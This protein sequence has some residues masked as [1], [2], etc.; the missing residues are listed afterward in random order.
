[1]GFPNTTPYFK[2]SIFSKEETNYI[3][4]QSWQHS[5]RN[6]LQEER[7]KFSIRQSSIEYWAFENVSLS[8]YSK[9]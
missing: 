7:H 4:L 5:A 1:M 8:K 2:N 3:A 6:S 9:Q